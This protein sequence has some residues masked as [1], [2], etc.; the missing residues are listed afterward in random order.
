MFNTNG[1]VKKKKK[2]DEEFIEIFG[3]HREEVANFL[4]H[5][6]IGTKDMITMHG[7]EL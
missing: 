2:E 6:G 4:I 5:E 7:Y 3:D 1:A